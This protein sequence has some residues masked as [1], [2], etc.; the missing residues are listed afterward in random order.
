MEYFN[1]YE[2]ATRAEAYSKLDFC[3]T[4]YLAYRD[5]PDIISAHVKGKKAIDFGCGTGRSTRFLQRLGFATVGVDIA[6][7]M[8][9]KAIETDPE[10]DYRLIEDGG[11][12]Q[13]KNSDY[14]LALSAFTFDNIPAENK[15]KLLGKLGSLLKTEGRIVSL[16]SSPEIYINE[17]VSFS[18]RDFPENKDAK[19]GDKVKIITTDVKD[20]RPV[21]DF[22][23]TDKD[24][25]EI[26]KKAG[27]QLVNT[28]TPL[29][30]ENEPYRWV[31][32]TRIAPWVI[33]VLKRPSNAMATIREMKKEDRVSVIDIFNYYVEHSFA[34]YPEGKIPY[35]FYDIFMKS[36]GYPRI[37]IENEDG[38]VGFAMLRPHSPIPAFRGTAEISYFIKPDM[39]GRGLGARMLRHL[40]NEAG[41]KGIRS[42]LAG[43]SS[44]N[45]GSLRF[46]SKHGFKECGRFNGIGLKKGHYFDVVWMQL[47]L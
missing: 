31:N 23:C 33:Y 8:L 30:K 26:F 43:I 7:N 28:Y 10:G 45:E 36:E 38:V 21:E 34:A 5:L 2:D 9:K 16:V 41:V 1:C 25:Q 19:S 12:N 24:Y 35:E 11:L 40:L 18:T 14:D 27:L 42:I 13:F 17:W 20:N 32:E 47:A 4:Y 15:V 37:V 46:H 3:G 44:L 29:A 39:T 22:I 6:E